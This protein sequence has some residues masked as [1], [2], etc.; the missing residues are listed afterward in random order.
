[1]VLFS[2][3]NSQEKQIFLGQ[4]L[5]KKKKSQAKAKT[6]KPNTKTKQN[7]PSLS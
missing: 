1:V 4:A 2:I 7:T 5:V 6:P 3:I